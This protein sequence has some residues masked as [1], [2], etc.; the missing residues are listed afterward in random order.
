MLERDIPKAR[1]LLKNKRDMRFIMNSLVS[2]KI[3][4][5]AVNNEFNLKLEV[6]SSVLKSFLINELND[7]D[8][9]LKCIGVTGLTRLIN[10]VT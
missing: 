8:N 7:I 5:I 10:N 9:Q 1:E 2:E 3:S 4:T 6:R